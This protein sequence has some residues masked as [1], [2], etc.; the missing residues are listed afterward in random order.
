MT[1][2]TILYIV[3]AALIS[4]ALALF[5]YGYKSKYSVTLRWTFGC[6]RF[7]TLFSILLLLINPKFRSETF[8]LE[9][10]K[11][12]V[13]VDNSA[14]VVELNQSSNVLGLVQSLK[15]NA[16]LNEKFDVSFYNFGSDLRDTDSL[17]FSEKNTNISKALSTTN[18]LF[19]NEKSPTVL[20][21]D[22]N[23]TLGNDYEFSIASFK[24]P[25]YPVI[26]G[27]STK[28]TDLK[29]EQLNTNRYAFLKNQFPVEVILTY[30]GEAAVNSQFVVSQGAAIVFRETVSFT[31]TNNAKTLSFTLPAASVGLQKYTAQLIP[32]SDEKNKVNNSKQ[33]AVE[34]IDQATNVLLVSDLLHPDLGALKK[35]ITSNEQRTVTL[36]KP[37]EAIS[38][39]NE[40][41]LILLYQPNRSFTAL[42]QEIDKLKKNTF[43][44]SGIQTDWNF[45]NAAQDNFNKEVT[46]QT[47][48]VSGTVNHNYGTF[49]VSASG[50]NSF[51]PLQTLFGG[52]EVTVPHEV[53]LEQHING[54]SSESAMLAT[55]ELNGKRDAIWDGEGLWKWRAE[56]YLEH[57]N[58]QEF[59]DFV[60]KLIQY[61]ASNTRRSRLE[62]TNE[63]FYYNNSLVRIIAQYFDQ[64]FVFDPRASLHIQITNTETNARTEFPM[65]LRNNFYEVDLNS[66]EAGEYRYTVSGQEEAIARSGNFTILDFNVEQQFLNANVTK[67]TKVAT[68]SNGKAFFITEFKGLIDTLLETDKFKPIQK[69][70]EKV[71]PLIDWKFLLAFIVLML[72]SEWFIRKYNGLI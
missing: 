33:F 27:D 51:R 5:M 39:L 18:Q 52:L 23:Q 25:I 67:L 43:V 11:L 1:A 46:N 64:N 26:L 30:S 24:D 56:S 22:G 41:Q 14:S 54:I 34:V 7:F 60:G 66:L 69:S 10:P 37:A 32:L 16:E 71:V 6:L 44:I 55:M 13:L 62:V 9:K 2:E 38:L 12:P 21:T 47:E 59:D 57:T 53:L 17:S 4:L 8:T 65:L 68:N 40:Y 45:L 72:T 29:I 61:L 70:E 48:Y 31:E 28:Y 42:F 58:F 3:I 49:A 63:T 19:R 15:D 36:K 35:A 20:I 50:F